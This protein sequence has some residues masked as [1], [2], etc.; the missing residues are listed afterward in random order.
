[1]R[2]IQGQKPTEQGESTRP[3]Q[4]WEWSNPLCT[5]G[6]PVLTHIAEQSRAVNRYVGSIFIDVEKCPHIFQVRWQVAI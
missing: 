1:M 5:L 4:G 3:Q 6:T 2:R